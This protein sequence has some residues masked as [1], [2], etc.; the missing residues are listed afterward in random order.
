MASRKINFLFGPRYDILMHQLQ[1]DLPQIVLSLLC[2]VAGILLL[3][4]QIFLSVRNKQSDWELFY[5]G[6]FTPLIVIWRIT[7]TRFSTILLAQNP[8]MLSTMTLGAL[9]L[10]ITPIPLYLCTRYRGTEKPLLIVAMGTC[11]TT[12]FAL[13]C[14]LLDVADL[15]ETLFICHLSLIVAVKVM[16]PH[17]TNRMHSYHNR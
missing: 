1:S 8:R 9:F 16:Y 11:L 6:V 4:A 14:Q 5:L 15:R 17:Q 2:I 7:D 10:A 13:V 3:A 12:A